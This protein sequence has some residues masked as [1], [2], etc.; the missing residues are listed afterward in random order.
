MKKSVLVLVLA[1]CCV[2]AASAQYVVVGPPVIVGPT[3][4][5]DPP[6]G[7]VWV[8][9][10]IHTTGTWNWCPY[11]GWEWIETSRHVHP[12]HWHHQG[13]YVTGPW[14]RY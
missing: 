9:E 3:I 13:V 11:H 7:W 6:S 12:G 4:V 10:T 8:S 14:Y 5:V 2:S 1:L